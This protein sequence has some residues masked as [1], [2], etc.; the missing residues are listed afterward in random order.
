MFDLKDDL[1]GWCYTEVIHWRS[2][3]L[4]ALSQT[5]YKEG[6]V[7]PMVVI[8][9]LPHAI[10]GPNDHL[11][12]APHFTILAWKIKDETVTALKSQIWFDCINVDPWLIIFQNWVCEPIISKIWNE[13]QVV[14]YW[15]CQVLLHSK[16][17]KDSPEQKYHFIKTY[18]N[19]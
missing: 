18:L 19:K 13:R 11:E 12:D 14:P 17:Y 6:Y 5:V 9:I 16:K 7:F 8:S 2:E 10:F 3:I 4:S 1:Q 15:V